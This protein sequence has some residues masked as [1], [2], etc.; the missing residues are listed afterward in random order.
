M[1]FMDQDIPRTKL[2]KRK[3]ENLKGKIIAIIALTLVTTSAITYG[4]FYP[5]KRQTGQNNLVSECFNIEF[6]NESE[7]IALTNAYPVSDEEGRKITPYSFTI[8]STCDLATSYHIVIDTKTGSS[9]L[10][11]F[12]VLHL[13]S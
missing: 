10:A 2:Q 3:K 9:T 7:S 5:N 4:F 12:L 6:T 11:I 1:T 13:L 8:T